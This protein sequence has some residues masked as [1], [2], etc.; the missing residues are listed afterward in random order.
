MHDSDPNQ[1]LK[2]LGHGNDVCLN[3][4]QAI[5]QDISAHTHHPLNSSGSEC[6]NCH[7]PR[8][9][10]ALFRAMRSHRVDI[11]SAATSAASGRP[12]ACNLCHLDK[13]LLWTAERMQDWYGT[14]VPAAVQSHP[15]NGAKTAAS[16][17]WLLEGDAAQRVV[18]AWHFGWGP[19][20][21]ASGADW[22][23][24]VLAELLDDPYSAVRLVAGR[25]LKTLPNMSELDF[26]FLSP[27]T[28]RQNAK[29][30]AIDLWRSSPRQPTLNPTAVLQLDSGELN[31]K[32]IR[33]MLRSQ[34][35]RPVVL[36]E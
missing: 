6:Y 16:I 8:T 12:I 30:R 19:A 25:S 17:E 22:E 29:Q 1:Q 27:T 15:Q 3:C 18:T 35:Q 5:S 10:Y 23:A 34:N 2:S 21:E 33:R 13:S 32:E 11:P 20:H 14:D 7:M 4:H 31:E 26:D 28:A 9:S 36:S 24:P